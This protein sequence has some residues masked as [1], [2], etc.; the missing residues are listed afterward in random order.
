MNP[1]I[2]TLAILTQL[3]IELTNEDVSPE[4]VYEYLE[5]LSHDPSTPENIQAAIEAV[6]DWCTDEEARIESEESDSDDDE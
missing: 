5:F 6:L 3:E 2:S 1:S 4:E